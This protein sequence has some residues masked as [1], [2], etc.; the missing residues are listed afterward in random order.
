MIHSDDRSSGTPGTGGNQTGGYVVKS[1]QSAPAG[2][3]AKLERSARLA[4]ESFGYEEPLALPSTVSSR[5]LWCVA[6][7]IAG[8]GLAILALR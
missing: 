4:G 7:V 2:H 1:R 5:L 6:A 3:I 8:F